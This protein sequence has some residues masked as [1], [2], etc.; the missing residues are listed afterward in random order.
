[1]GHFESPPS[2]WPG[3]L[4]VALVVG[5]MEAVVV[6]VVVVVVVAVHA[7]GVVLCEV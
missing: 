7:V 5:L 6:A 3:Q 1:L 4:L 2:K